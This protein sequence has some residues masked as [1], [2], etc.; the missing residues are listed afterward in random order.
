[1][2]GRNSPAGQRGVGQWEG[3]ME[4]RKG[5]GAEGWR[6]ERGCLRGTAGIHGGQ[7]RRP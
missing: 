1:M 4:K 2:T 6:S 5:G 3:E 7:V